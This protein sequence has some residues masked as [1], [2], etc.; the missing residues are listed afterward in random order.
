M[1][2]VNA[3][4]A[5]RGRAPGELG[6]LVGGSA[7]A[8]LVAAVALVGSPLVVPVLVAGVVAVYLAAFKPKVFALAGIVAIVL[9]SLLQAVL[10]S[11]AGYTDEAVVVL[12]LIA[13][14]TRRLLTTGRLVA[15]PGTG[16]FLLFVGLGVASASVN[17]VPVSISAQALLL[18]TKGLLFAFALAQLDWTEKDLGTLV[19]AGV[20]TIA[21]VALSGVVNLLAPGLSAAATGAIERAG[22]G[23]LPALT[24]LFDHPAAFGRFCAILA[25]A[26]LVYGGV[27]RASWGNAGLIVAAAGLALLSFQVKSLVGMLVALAV[28]GVR[29]ARPVVVWVLIGLGP[30]I[31]LL[32]VPPVSGYVGADVDQYVVQDSARLTL[33]LG[34]FD[35]AADHA[36]LGAGFGRYGS[37]PAGEHY[38]PEYVSR[39]F[40]SVYGLGRD[41]AGM[42]LNDTQWPALIGETGWFGAGAFALGLVSVAIALMRRTGPDERPL[43]RWI[44]IT[45]VG[46]LTLLLVESLAGPVF[47]SAPSYPFVFAAAGIVASF[48]AQARERETPELAYPAALPGYAAVP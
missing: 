7:T 6:W 39:H 28:V 42:F 47:V 33:T 40:E 11:I 38:S 31:A 5:V 9:T 1:A 10:G 4:A 46:W 14:T 45:G 23:G 26:A 37:F 19:R 43:V 16:W 35:V 41:D 32:L 3:V 44:R 18:I 13:F 22:A 34:S 24:G 12:A 15:F 8:V 30:V 27:V 36:P 20:V 17:A 48:R 25:V 29:L 2:H 21:V